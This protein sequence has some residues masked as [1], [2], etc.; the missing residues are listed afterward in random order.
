MNRRGV[1]LI[2]ILVALSLF[3]LVGSGA[4]YVLSAQNRNWKLASDQSDM[5][6]TA[7]SVLDELSRSFRMVGSGLPDYAGGMVVYG[8][9]A[10]RVTLVM[11]ESG[12][13][14][15]V[16]GSYWDRTAKRLRIA[17]HDATRFEYLGYARIDLRVPPPGLHAASGLSTQSFSLGIVDRTDAQGSCGDSLILDTSPLQN[18]PNYWTNAGDIAPLVNGTVQNIDS[19]TYR[20][21]FDTLYVK[22]N[23][24]AETIFATGLDSLRFWYN[25]PT[26]G[27]QDS[28]S[29]VYPANTVNKVRVRIVLRTSKVDSKLLAQVPSSRGYQ[30][31]RMET[32]QALRNTNLTNR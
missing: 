18:A 7:K 27:W 3:V 1:T 20:K 2:E 24:Q 30:F 6:M 28:L 12:A 9:G 11:N 25:H 22:R 4:M 14:D 29:P 26:A 8:S 21:S 32:D 23:I 17:V 16:L 5:N 10:E 15:T 13:D 19:V 31:W